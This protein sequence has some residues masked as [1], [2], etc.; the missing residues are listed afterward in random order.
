MG[1]TVA[2]YEMV[3]NAVIAAATVLYTA[4]CISHIAA[5]WVLRKDFNLAVR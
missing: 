5:A 2:W 4:I 1:T 3:L